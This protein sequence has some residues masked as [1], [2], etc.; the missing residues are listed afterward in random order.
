MKIII[1]LLI[2]IHSV[3]TTGQDNDSVV[4]AAGGSL[5]TCTTL[6]TANCSDTV[7]LHKDSSY[8]TTETYLVT[9]QALADIIA[10]EYWRSVG[11]VQLKQLQALLQRFKRNHPAP[12]KRSVFIDRFRNLTIAQADESVT[13]EQYYKS[14]TDHDWYMLLD[15]LQVPQFLDGQRIGEQV[16]L[17]HSKD[18]ATATIFREF[19]AMAGRVSNEAG[20]LPMILVMTSSARDPYDAVDFYVQVF[21]QAGATVKWLPLDQ[22]MQVA[23]DKQDCDNLSAYRE[24]LS[25]AVRRDIVFPDLYQLQQ[26]Y[27]R[28]PDKLLQLIEQADGIFINGGD[29]SLTRATLMPD[30]DSQF[31]ALIRDR[32]G[33]GELVIGGTSAGAA[34]QSG[35]R[36]DDADI[37]MISSGQS[38]A[39]VVHGVFASAPPAEG[40]SK[41][42]SCNGI[43]D[44]AVTYNKRGGLGLINTG[45]VDTHFS[46]R[47]RQLRLMKLAATTQSSI[48]VGVDET[49]AVTI[50]EDSNEI[51]YR[52][53]GKNGAWFF[54]NSV[55]KSANEAQTLSA[56][57]H[58]LTHGDRL[59]FNKESGEVITRLSGVELSANNNAALTPAADILYRDSMR[60]LSNQLAQSERTEISTLTEQTNPQLNIRLSKGEDYRALRVP[61]NKVSQQPV[62]YS[63]LDI[64]VVVCT[65]LCED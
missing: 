7:E 34:V 24:A 64:S 21:T 6:S 20:Q 54:L 48:A 42:D 62:S 51:S 35:Q 36:L 60:E 3:T 50:A 28:A 58:Y 29:Q 13:G 47:G 10:S 25:G 9:D 18:A 44:N 40:C 17:D 4:M 56:T 49:T 57:A 26:H 63:G 59:I 53:V 37:P 1:L 12:L 43:P 61:A 15:Y 30:G 55:V 38:Y 41:N 11:E 8:K 52:V 27:C 16:F 19:V 22:A 14:L 39:G 31:M 33:K 65:G 45:I 23:L 5:K 2:I 46:E 32:V